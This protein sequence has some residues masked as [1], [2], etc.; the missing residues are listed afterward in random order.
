MHDRRQAGSIVVERR[1][2]PRWPLQ[3]D[4]TCTCR[5]ACFEAITENLT[6]SGAF[7]RTRMSVPVGTDVELTLELSDGGEPA[8]TAGR[9]V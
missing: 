9:V 8:K 5:D 3:V 1:Q 6:E 7:V 4:V 2:S